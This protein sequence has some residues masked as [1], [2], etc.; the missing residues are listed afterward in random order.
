MQ[1][2][3]AEWKTGSERGMALSATLATIGLVKCP[4]RNQAP[5]SDKN[6]YPV[7]R[8]GVG[9]SGSRLVPVH[10]LEVI[11]ITETFAI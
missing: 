4:V 7:H 9:D 5:A 3:M 6:G 8:T 10:K 2:K 1:S 11:G